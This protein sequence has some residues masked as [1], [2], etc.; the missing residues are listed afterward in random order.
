MFS[1]NVTLSYIAKDIRSVTLFLITTMISSTFTGLPDDTQVNIT[2]S[3]V[4]R[5][6]D[7]LS[8]D[9]TFVRTRD[10]GS[11]YKFTSC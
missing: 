9:F 8:I 10:Y 3:G 1:Y 7:V 11:M 5:N 6:L 2:V 4:N